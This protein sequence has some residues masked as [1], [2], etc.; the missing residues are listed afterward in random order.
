MK[1]EAGNILKIGEEKYEVLNMFEDID[2]F[3]T[4]KNQPIGT[5]I[6]IELHKMGDPSLHPTH[7]LKIY[8]NNKENAILLRIVQEKPTVE[9]PRQRGIWFSHVDKTEVPIKEIKIE[10][11]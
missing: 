8:E 3:D 2:L 1:L 5:H 10:K 7:L 4:E 9:N 11:E 6:A